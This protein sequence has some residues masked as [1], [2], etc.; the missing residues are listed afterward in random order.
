MQEELRSHH[1]WVL[2]PN[3]PQHLQLQLLQHQGFMQTIILQQF[4]QV[5]EQGKQ[6]HTLKETITQIIGEQQRPASYIESLEAMLF[7][8]KST[9]GPEAPVRKATPESPIAPDV[10]L[11]HPEPVSARIKAMVR[12][13]MEMEAQYDVVSYGMPSRGIQPITLGPPLVAV[14]NHQILLIHLKPLWPSRGIRPVRPGPPLVA[15]ANN[16]LLQMSLATHLMRVSCQC[17]A[18][19]T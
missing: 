15:V 4:Q 10:P 9:G 2:H 7:R 1:L 11:K 13:A 6:I 17:L 19:A 5:I 16:H 14:A 18:V 8:T 3:L 12:P